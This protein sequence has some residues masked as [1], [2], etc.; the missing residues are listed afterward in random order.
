[1]VPLGL[2]RLRLVRIRGILLRWIVVSSLMMLLLLLLL[3]LVLLLVVLG[4]LP[5]LRLGIAR[6]LVVIHG[7]LMMCTRIKMCREDDE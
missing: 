4:V 7:V 5:R 6:V 3:L 1:M 2:R